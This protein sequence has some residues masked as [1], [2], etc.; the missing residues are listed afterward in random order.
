MLCYEKDPPSRKPRHCTD[1]DP[2]LIFIAV[3]L[4]NFPII[5]MLSLEGTRVLRVNLTSL[6]MGFGCECFYFLPLCQPF[7]YLSLQ[8]CTLEMAKIWLKRDAAKWNY[9]A[10][11]LQGRFCFRDQ[12]AFIMVMTG[13][14]VWA[15]D[16]ELLSWSDISG[17]LVSGRVHSIPWRFTFITA[18][19]IHKLWSSMG[20]EMLFI[21]MTTSSER[22][23][24]PSK[25]LVRIVTEYTP[26]YSLKDSLPAIIYLIIFSQEK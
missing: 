20:K 24:D 9:Y 11:C 21:M 5:L 13:L 17:F 8:N 10:Y 1:A 6:A 18:V 3:Y 25:A 7:Q 4:Q 16:R 2:C 15:L 14:R 23:A 12:H 22:N 19:R 26:L